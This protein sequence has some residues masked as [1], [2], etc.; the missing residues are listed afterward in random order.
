M[1]AKEEKPEELDALPA[2]Q[3][4]SCKKFPGTNSAQGKTAYLMV[5]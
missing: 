2:F 5:L 4:W 3:N 1:A